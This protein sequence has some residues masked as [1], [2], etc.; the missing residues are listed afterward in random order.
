MTARSGRRPPPRLPRA[1]PPPPI[2]PAAAGPGGSSPGCSSWRGWG[3]AGPGMP[4]CCRSLDLLPAGWR[5]R[6]AEIAWM[7]DWAERSDAAC[8]HVQP[9]PASD[10]SGGL[11]LAGFA[12][13]ADAFTGLRGAFAEAHG[14]PPDLEVTRVSEPQCATLDFLSGL[15]LPFAPEPPLV[16]RLTPPAEAGDEPRRPARRGRGQQVALLLIDPSGRLQN[17][18]AARRSRN[19]GLFPAPPPPA[20]HG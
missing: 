9:A 7:A 18:S 14:P 20:R 15:D 1:T 17:L 11:A 2:R 16:L 8:R 12:R 4:G 6:D 3:W 19:R 10:E 13:G 5:D